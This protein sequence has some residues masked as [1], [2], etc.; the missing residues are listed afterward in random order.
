[1][2]NGDFL[3]RVSGR[4][5]VPWKW[6]Q[7]RHVLQFE[8]RGLAHDAPPAPARTDPLQHEDGP[9]VPPLG[10]ERTVWSWRSA[11]TA[12]SPTLGDDEGVHVILGDIK[13]AAG[14]QVGCVVLAQAT[15]PVIV[16]GP[17]GAG[18]ASP[19]CG[20]WAPYRITPHMV[21]TALRLQHGQRLLLLWWPGAG[22]A[23]EIVAARVSFCT[24][25]CFSPT[26]LEVHYAVHPDQDCPDFSQFETVAAEAWRYCP[27]SKQCQGGV[28]VTEDCMLVGVHAA[29]PR[30]GQVPDPWVDFCW[31]AAPHVAPATELSGV[32]PAD[33]RPGTAWPWCSAVCVVAIVTELSAKGPLRQ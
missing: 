22:P 6:R 21:S 18:S 11:G 8:Q 13:G 9:C 1:M 25:L 14:E 17:G 29:S 19:I 30:D 5:R 28:I 15:N 24:F 27:S 23:G 4:A 31:Q 26:L 32:L 20:A 12:P 10:M 33:A 16:A 3:F 7:M 2:T